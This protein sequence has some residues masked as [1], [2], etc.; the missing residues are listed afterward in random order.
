[1][2]VTRNNIYNETA[3]LNNHYDLRVP[4]TFTSYH[5]QPVPFSAACVLCQTILPR[6]R[7][8]GLFLREVLEL[9]WTLYLPIGCEISWYT[10]IEYGIVLLTPY[11]FTASYSTCSF[12]L[13][14]DHFLCTSPPYELLFDHHCKPLLL[15]P[16]TQRHI[17]NHAY[18]FHLH[19][20][21]SQ[22]MLTVSIIF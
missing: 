22:L 4:G 10:E 7:D 12:L 15:C 2:V 6:I 14:V 8:C 18:C 5:T 11:S 19:Y 3:K 17:T 13:F 20:V 1:M 16:F 9:V 21:I